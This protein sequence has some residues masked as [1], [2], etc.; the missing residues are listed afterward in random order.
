MYLERAGREGGHPQALTML[1]SLA[2][3]EGR[4]KE[5]VGWYQEGGE[6]GSEEAWRNL[7]AM[8]MLGEGVEKDEATARYIVRTVL[9]KKGGREGGEGGHGAP[10]EGRS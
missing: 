5:A 10:G 2:Y 1:G 3:R 8:Y 6:A 7:A 9:K 4:F